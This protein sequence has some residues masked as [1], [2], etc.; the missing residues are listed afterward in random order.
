[1]RLK[2][3]FTSVA[4]ASIAIAGLMVIGGDLQQMMVFLM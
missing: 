2:K 1:M 3:I 4:I